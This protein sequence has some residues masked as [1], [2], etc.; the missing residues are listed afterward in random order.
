MSNNSASVPS[1]EHILTADGTLVVY[2]DPKP[3]PRPAPGQPGTYSNYVPTEP[4]LFLAMLDDGR[5]LAFNGHVDLG[6]GIRTSLA[7]IVAEELDIAP[8]KVCMILGDPKDVPNQGPTIASATIQITA[9]PLRKAAAQAKQYLLKLAA[10]KLATDVDK[11]NVNR[12]VV[13]S[14]VNPELNISYEALLKGARHELQHDDSVQVKSPAEYKTVGTSFGRVDIPKKATGQLTFVHDM[15]VPGMLHGRVIRPP[16][17]GRDSGEFV[18]TSLIRIDRHSIDHIHGIVDIV[19]QGDFVGVVAE[20]EE[21]AIKA[22]NELHVE[23]K[24]PPKLPDLNNLEKVLREIP[25]KYRPL[26][27]QGDFERASQSGTESIAHT[28]IWPYNLHGSIGPSCALADCTESSLKVWSGTQNPHSLRNHLSSLMDLDEGAIEVVRMEASGCY[29]RNCA[30]DV[31]GDAA[32]LSRAVKKPV[33]VQLSREQEHGWEPKG[34]AQLMDAEAVLDKDRI[35]AYKFSTRYPS[36]D[37]PLLALVLTGKEDA[38]N[39]IFEMG[40]RTAVPPYAYANLDISCDDAPPVV[41]SAWL[42]GVSALPNT[43]AHECMID[44]LASRAGADPIEFRISHLNDERVISLI[45]ELKENYGWQSRVAGKGTQTADGGLKGRG[46]AYAHYVHSK[47]PGFGAAMAAWILELTV[48]PETG[49][50]KIDRVV[51]AQDAGLIVNPAG[52]QHQVHGNI[53]QTLSRCIK[54]EVV[55]N[56]DQPTTLEWGSYPILKFNELPQIDILLL[57]KPDEAPLGVGE[58]AALP[59]APAIANALFDATGVRF[60]EAPFTPERIRKRLAAAKV[61]TRSQPVPA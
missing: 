42:R 60:Y 5:T 33:R 21:Q 7:Q 53:I 58:S 23:W 40:D 15:R 30:D 57:N 51:A 25:A 9:Q 6:T 41:R 35:S 61:S 56:S 8:E 22:A 46:F 20:R 37:A 54:E 50:I 52:V 47:F 16:Y 17:V 1:R 39:R 19:V 4:E 3:S 14:N 26:R 29:G 32:L 45:N 55:F 10:D 27:Q 12:G 44:E 36:N 59:C 11:L 49:E 18:G 28:Y 2:R 34:T 38:S 24:T 13:E 48:Y 43:F 31:C